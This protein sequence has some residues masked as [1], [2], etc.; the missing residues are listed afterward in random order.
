M[1]STQEPQKKYLTI[2]EK[3]KYLNGRRSKVVK[4]AIDKSGKLLPKEMIVSLHYSYITSLERIKRKAL[5][6]D[7]T[8]SGSENTIP[9]Y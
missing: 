7:S 1:Q 3:E 5:D 6:T 8:P 2:E 4:N 9:K